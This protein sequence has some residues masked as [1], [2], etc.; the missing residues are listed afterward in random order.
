MPQGL[1]EGRAGKQ[2]APAE[3]LL[4]TALCWSSQNLDGS[5]VDWGFITPFFG[6]GKLQTRE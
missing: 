5:S 1:S 6:G 4:Y 2:V 3:C